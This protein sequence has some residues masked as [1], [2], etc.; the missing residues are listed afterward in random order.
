MRH[1]REQDVIDPLR[2]LGQ[3]SHQ[4]R[5]A[6]PVQDRPPRRDAVDD[7]AAVGQFQKFVVRPDARQRLIRVQQRR[8]RMP[9]RRRSSAD[10]SPV[11][12]AGLL[13]VIARQEAA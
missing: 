8:V 13:V 1:P 4:R 6:M 3:R 11:N 5:M 2:R 10:C 7:L 9:N 12:C